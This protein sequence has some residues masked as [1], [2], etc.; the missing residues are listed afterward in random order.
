MLAQLCSQSAGRY[1]T[2]NALP[3]VGVAA[4]VGLAG[5]EWLEDGAAG[6]LTVRSR[7]EYEIYAATERP[8]QD[9]ANRIWANS[10][11]TSLRLVSVHLHA[12]VNSVNV[13]VKFHVGRK[14]CFPCAQFML[15]QIQWTNSL[16]GIE[17][18]YCVC[19]LSFEVER[20]WRRVMKTALN[21]KFRNT[22]SLAWVSV[23]LFVNTRVKLLLEWRWRFNSVRFSLTHK[24]Y[25]T[26]YQFIEA[27]SLPIT[28]RKFR[29][30]G[31]QHNAFKF[32]S[33]PAHPQQS[34]QTNS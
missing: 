24:L 14:F 28:H 23:L 3:G 5:V 8:W 11:L 30:V 26:Q 4:G 29:N 1:R 15:C 13:E 34:Q 19:S 12:H 32:T 9:S 10:H 31:S 18:K 2:N 33:Y 7:Y 17:A 25:G 27:L 16:V 6:T 21:S 20:T 22:F